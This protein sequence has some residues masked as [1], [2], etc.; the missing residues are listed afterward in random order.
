MKKLSIII[1][2]YNEERT[3]AEIIARVKAVDLA[4]LEKEIIVVDNNSK[5][6]TFEIAS[7]IDGIRVLKE[8]TPGKGA[9]VRTGF[10]AATGDVLIIQDA[11]LEYDPRDYASVIAPILEGK[12]EAVVG[13]R[14]HEGHTPTHSTAYT[15]GNT[16]ITQAT[17]ILFGGNAAEYTGCYK[18]FTKR[19]ID[20]IIV[21]SDDFA[22]EHELVCKVL[23]YG[24][25]VF[26]VPIHYHPRDYKEG[27]KIN[28][29]DGFHIL[30]AVIKY[31]FVD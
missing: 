30:F 1:P 4:P 13:I 15:I 23:K 16:L 9:A 14:K 26:S 25:T 8:P 17:N 19:L 22:Y 29:R 6:R 5:D 28:W 10:A 3:L 31:R 21:R 27:K 12:T 2:A 18:A 24:G 7:G 20:S 11:D